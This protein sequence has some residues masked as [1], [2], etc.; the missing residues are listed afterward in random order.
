[1]REGNGDTRQPSLLGSARGRTSP[2]PNQN[3]TRITRSRYHD[4]LLEFST[5]LVELKRGDA[6]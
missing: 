4:S 3:L 5:G 1:M 2:W 6:K